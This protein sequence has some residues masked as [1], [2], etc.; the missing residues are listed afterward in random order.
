M[1]RVRGATAGQRCTLLALMMNILV[2]PLLVLQTLVFILCSPAVLPLARAVTGRPLGWLVRYF[3]RMYG[4]VWMVVM[5]PFVRFEKHDL[6]RD[7][8]PRPCII[9]L[10]HLSFFDIFCMGALPFSNGA[11]AIRS[12]P[13]RMLWY[14]PFM[15]LAEYVDMESLGKDE[16][17][18]R[19]RELLSRGVSL[20]FF[21]EGHRSRD[22]RIGRF[23]SGAFK[24]AVETNTPVVPLCIAGTDQ[25]LPAG[26]F[27]M[28][29]AVVRLQALPAINPADFPGE[30]GHIELRKHVKSVMVEAL[31][32]TPEHPINR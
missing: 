6:T 17:L 24:L 26:R 13:F 4:Q 27:V 18:G 11:F 10:N 3:I 31:E 7:R 14:A 16:A 15:R 9:A 5:S 8:F 19:C 30:S 1:T 2:Y 25:L 22:G 20:M 23:Y 29:P 21:P 28:A 12:W 32:K